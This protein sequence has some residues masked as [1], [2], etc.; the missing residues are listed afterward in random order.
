VLLLLLSPLPGPGP[1]LPVPATWL[2]A[3]RERQLHFVG[4]RIPEAFALQ[5]RPTSSWRLGP[6]G[7]LPPSLW[8]DLPTSCLWADLSCRAR[9][10]LVLTLG[11]CRRFR[12]CSCRQLSPRLQAWL[13]LANLPPFFL[14]SVETYAGAL[15]PAAAFAAYHAATC[16][17]GSALTD[18]ACRCGFLRAQRAAAARGKPHAE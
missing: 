16:M 1:L 8:V 12:M 6:A 10:L 11:L 4:P 14:L 15:L 2:V 3:A 9:P 13:C 7:E 17:L 18:A 5:V